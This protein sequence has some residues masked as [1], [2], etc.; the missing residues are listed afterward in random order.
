MK[1]I[2]KPRLLIEIY[3]SQ[4]ISS[5]DGFGKNSL[6]TPGSF[7]G[8]PARNLSVPLPFFGSLFNPFINARCGTKEAPA[9]MSFDD[10]PEEEA[11]HAFKVSG[12]D[13]PPGLCYI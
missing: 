2:S 7:L 13:L 8:C 12:V 5:T 6:F 1:S 9:E 11:Y 10:C 3:T 4:E